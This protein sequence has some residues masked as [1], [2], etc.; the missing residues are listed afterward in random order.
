MP[1]EG[2]KF[3]YIIALSVY[4]RFMPLFIYHSYE[5]GVFW[6]KINIAN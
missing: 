2:D 1:Q 4:K 5:L 3:S 6:I